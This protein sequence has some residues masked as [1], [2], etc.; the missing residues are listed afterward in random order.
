MIDTEI[1]ISDINSS[2]I[3]GTISTDD[4]E[5]IISDEPELEI[6]IETG[7][8]ELE[9][10]LYDGGDIDID[11][12]SSINLD[13]ELNNAIVPTDNYNDLINKP[14]IN[15]VTLVGNR[16]LEELDI[17]KSMENITN[18]DIERLISD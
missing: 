14:Q 17:Q 12:S 4:I 10:E 3:D 13:G 6:D 5:L 11:V 1:L 9:G 7:E 8:V 16:S 18:M 15:S 2:V